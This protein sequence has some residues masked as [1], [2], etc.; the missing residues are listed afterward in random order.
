MRVSTRHTL[1]AGA[2]AAVIGALTMA[3]SA[4][5]G[6]SPCHGCNAPPPPPPS[7]HGQKD[8]PCCQGGKN[9]GVFVPGVNVY[10]GSVNVSVQT[11]LNVAA[12]AGA[13]AQSEVVAYAGGGGGFGGPAP[14]AMTSIDNLNVVGGGEI[15]TET[16]TEQVPTVEEYCV[17]EISYEMAYRAVQAVC[18]DDTGAPHPASQVN[19]SQSIAS[20]YKGEVFRCMAGTRMQVTIGSVT[21]GKASFDH[22]QGMSCAKGEALV[23]STG[24]KLNCAP[25]SP[26]RDCNE[27]SLLRRHGPGIKVFETRIADKRCVPQERTVMKSVT[28]EVQKVRESA[29]G[30]IVFD[31]GVGQG[32]Y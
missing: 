10:G 20:G 12:A 31:G 28:R 16:V 4:G 14:V 1:Y 32:V 5:G 23:F 13:S 17:D 15:Y 30:A 2:A 24:G 25:Q 27:R 18:I 22:G 11:S 3:A 7:Y 26:Q 29:G 9:H 21:Q 19:G 8:G 6:N